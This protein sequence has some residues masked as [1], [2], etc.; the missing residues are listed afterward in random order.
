MPNNLAVYGFPDNYAT[1]VSGSANVKYVSATGSNSNDGNSPTTPYLTIAQ[2]LSATSGI[3]TSVTIVIMAGTYT[4][5]PGVA[6]GTVDAIAGLSDNNLP[7]KFV[8]C[9]GQTIIQ[10]TDSG[11]QRDSCMV[12]FRNSSSVLYGAKLLRNNNARTTNYTVAFF[13]SSTAGTQHGTFYNCVFRETNTNNA[14]SFQ[15]DNA[16]SQNQ[17]IYNSTF[18]AGAAALGN[19]TSSLSVILTDSVVNTTV[20]SGATETNV[21]KSQTVDSTTYV[22]TGVTTAGVYSGTYAW[23]GTLTLP[24]YA[25]ITSTTGSPVMTEVTIGSDYYRIYKFTSSGSI[26]VG[27]AGIVDVLVVAGGGG[28]STIA[29]G[30]WSGTGGGGAGGVVSASYFNVSAT[31]YTIIVGAGGTNTNVNAG[32]PSTNSGGDSVAFGFTAKGGGGGGDYTAGA[33]GGSGGGG[34]YNGTAGGSTTQLSFAGATSYGYAGG[35]AVSGI[36]GGGGGGGAGSVGAVGTGSFGGDGGSGISHSITGS[37]ITYAA[38]GGGGT[39]YDY[40]GAGGSSGV[41]GRGAGTLQSA[42]NG[43]IYTGSGGGGTGHYSGSAANPTGGLGGSGVVIVRVKAPRP[44]GL[45]ASSNAISSGNSVTFSLLSNTV[46]SGNVAYTISGVTSTQINNASLTGNI[47]LANYAGNLVVATTKSAIMSATLSV[48]ADTY[49]SDVTVTYPVSITTSVARPPLATSLTTS[50]PNTIKTSVMDR[51]A[52]AAISGAQLDL[53]NNQK[54]ILNSTRTVSKTG[55]TVMATV[56]SAD[57]NTVQ[58]TVSTSMM[59]SQSG[60]ILGPRSNTTTT[61]SGGVMNTYVVQPGGAK[62]PREYWM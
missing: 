14:W 28:G 43:T 33:S 53:T 15:Y 2:A 5:T 34:G 22:T 18:Y 48:T 19:Y 20:T 1:V 47:V 29:T 36:G 39:Y 3:A 11:G 60:G 24:D 37:A 51:V 59:N 50:T 25:S 35:A 49:T 4:V 10:W 17:K 44:P 31:T 32:T 30:G 8:C 52:N 54:T 62:Q 16:G 9:P 6:T 27:T 13:N 40:G 21:L 23:N 41:G 61:T 46:A 42:G 12:D 26:V 38:G 45:Y 56:V 57:T 55:S 7:R 58:K